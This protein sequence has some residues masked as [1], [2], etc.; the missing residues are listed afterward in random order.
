ML[1]NYY[2]FHNLN[3]EKLARSQTGIVF[4]QHMSRLISRGRGS[5][6]EVIMHGAEPSL[7]AGISKKEA[8]KIFGFPEGGRIALALG[9]MT[10]T[11]GW[12]VIEKMKIPKGWTIVVNSSKNHYSTEN[13]NPDFVNKKSIVNLEKDF[14]TEKEFS[15]FFS[16][17]DAVILPYSVSSGS[18]VMFDALAHGLP[19]IATDLE[20]FREFSEKGLGITVSRS[21]EEFSQSLLILDRDYAKYFEA[22]ESFRKE[23]SWQTVANQ[24]ALIYARAISKKESLIAM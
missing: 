19:F 24:H 15:L 9:F 16:A 18:G 20:F 4:S 12:D 11:K 21:P 2:S 23:I 17:A 1:I 5:E 3:K 14:L 22:V 8:R 7:A 6:A 13:F 10:A